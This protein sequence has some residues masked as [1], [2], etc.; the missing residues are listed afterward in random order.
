MA[1]KFQLGPS[2][3]SGTLEQEGSIDIVDD[4]SGT[5]ELKVG[6]TAVVDSSR[7]VVV[8]NLFKMPDNTSGKFLV[9]DGTSYQEVAMSGDTTVS[10]AGAVT[11][12]DLKIK[13]PMLN[14][15]V[16]SGLSGSFTGDIA[17]TDEFL[18][19][20]TNVGQKKVDFSVVRDA[21]FADVSGDATVAAGGALTIANNAVENA[22]MADDSVGAAELIDDSVG[23]AAMADDAV[24]TA[25][26]QD[27]AVTLAKM[28]GLARGSIILGDSSGDPS[29]LAKGTAGQ[30]L[31]SDG[32]DLS[33]VTLSGDATIAAGGA[34]TIAANA[35][36]GS[37][38]NSN[39]AGAGLGYESNALVLQTSGSALVIASDK[40][41]I[42]GSIAGDCLDKGPGDGVD[43][44]RSLNVVADEST[45]ESVG[46]AALR[47]KDDGVTGAKLA[48][49]VAGVGLKQD[50]S[51]NL[52]LDLNEL[53]AAAVDV[54]ADSIAIV[55]ANDS[56]ASKKESIADLVAAMAGG[57]LSATNGVLSTQAGNVSTF[58]D[59]N[60]TLAEGMNA[61]SA[62]LTADRT[63]TL[64]AS[65]SSGDVI[66]VKAP[67]SLGGNELI[68]QKGSADHR[69]DGQESI[70]IESDGGAVSCMFIGNNAWVIF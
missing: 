53:T 8:G 12:G 48:P 31:Q 36:E 56:N 55:D 5:F 28:A 64:P 41:G 25:V 10:S 59:A 4:G 30:F 16:I 17:D 11:I 47:I 51:G 20:H 35:V 37:M 58:A 62:T 14:A 60:A 18:I 38:I 69:I 23:A 65:P 6:G 21:V 34:L 1:Y 54:A 40:L 32:T 52:D 39:A 33:Y 2:V 68:I 50:G 46:L 24:A 70:E 49:A 26:I 42:S 7:S 63:L 57:G 61:G 15:N 66:H 67:A 22:M 43:S 45:I 29:A 3:L 44:I 9:A 27:N 13:G 19:S